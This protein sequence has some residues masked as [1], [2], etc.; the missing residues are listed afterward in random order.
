MYTTKSFF[1]KTRINKTIDQI[2]LDP[3]L[4]SIVTSWGIE[5]GTTQTQ[6]VTLITSNLEDNSDG[7]LKIKRINNQLLFEK[8][9]KIN[10]NL[11]TIELSG[12]ELSFLDE[13]TNY[14]IS[15]YAINKIGK[16]TNTVTITFKTSINFKPD[17]PIIDKV[18]TSFGDI[19]KRSDRDVKIYAEIINV[20]EDQQ[21]TIK[22]V[23]DNIID[24]VFKNQ[25][26]IG[27]L[28]INIPKE[29]LIAFK[30][31]ITY[32]IVVDINNEC[33]S[34]AETHD[35]TRFTVD[36]PVFT[37]TITKK[38]I[39]DY[40]IDQPQITFYKNLL[41]NLDLLVLRTMLAGQATLYVAEEA[42]FIRQDVTI[43]YD[44][45]LYGNREKVYEIKDMNFDKLHDIQKEI[46]GIE[47]EYKRYNEK[48]G[49]TDIDEMELNKLREIEKDLY[50]N[51]IDRILYYQ[52]YNVDYSDDINIEKLTNIHISLYGDNL[53]K[54]IYEEL[55]GDEEIDDDKINE[56]INEIFL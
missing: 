31:N 22:I 14:K 52:T 3:K 39:A 46:Y 21:G 42:S 54:I 16:K 27:I 33:I 5:L 37:E 15:G 32:T 18:W 8:S 6:L 1:D 47:L 17:I 44:I 56:I 38:I 40:T 45:V 23:H 4:N 53:E 51:T 48:Y 49:E 28:E 34:F 29:L 35:T 26:N 13:D 11:G 9:L 24:F 30:K 7:Y 43:R 12:Y 20:L 19:L 41:E 10:K 55:Y 50:K 36:I 25:V 2:I